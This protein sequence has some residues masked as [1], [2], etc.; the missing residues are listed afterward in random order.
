MA[1]LMWLLI[2][3]MSIGSFSAFCFDEPSVA[4]YGSLLIPLVMLSNAKQLVTTKMGNFSLRKRREDIATSVLLVAL[5]ATT[6]ILAV[7]LML[8]EEEGTFKPEWLDWLG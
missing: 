7:Y 1:A 3:L 4:Y 8:Y 5:L 2:L 6:A